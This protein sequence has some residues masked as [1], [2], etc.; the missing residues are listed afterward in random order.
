[1]RAELQRRLQELEG[2]RKEFTS[3]QS[4]HKETVEELANH[5][6]KLRDA[7]LEKEALEEEV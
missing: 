6:K 5:C 2:V 1:M 3:L 7:L 4:K